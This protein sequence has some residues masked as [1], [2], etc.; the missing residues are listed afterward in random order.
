MCDDFWSFGKKKE[1]KKREKS[2]A[3]SFLS[4][5]PLFSFLNGAEK[6]H[7]CTH[8]ARE[9]AARGAAA[10]HTTAV[11]AATEAAARITPPSTT[12]T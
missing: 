11:A 6:M 2:F 12:K 7:K 1:R 5:R 4:L 9:A 3:L 10:D 8:R